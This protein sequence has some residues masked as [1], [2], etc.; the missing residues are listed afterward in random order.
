MIKE[1]KMNNGDVFDVGQTINGVSQ[2]LWFNKEWYYFVKG[3]THKYEYDQDD[4]TNLVQLNEFD[5]IKYLGNIL[6][7]FKLKYNE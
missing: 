6:D 1:I 2:F 4:L 3:L 7:N 5:E